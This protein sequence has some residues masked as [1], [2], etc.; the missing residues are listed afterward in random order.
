MTIAYVS[1]FPIAAHVKSVPPHEV[2]IVEK[3]I[4]SGFTEH[5]PDKLFGDKAYD[6]DPLDQKLLEDRGIEL[7][8]PHK[9]NRKKYSTQD[10]R[11]R[12]CYK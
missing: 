4:D 1:G 6:N 5:A 12:C 11:K 2:K 9:K 10:G 7:I 8:A 3:T